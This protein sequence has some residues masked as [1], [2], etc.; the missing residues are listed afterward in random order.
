MATSS[1]ALSKPYSNED[2][3]GNESDTSRFER[4]ATRHRRHEVD[5]DSERGSHSESYSTDDENSNKDLVKIV[6]A[7]GRKVKRRSSYDYNSRTMSS[8][9]SDGRIGNL[10]EDPHVP[11]QYLG[12]ARNSPP[13]ATLAMSAALPLA[14]RTAVTANSASTAFDPKDTMDLKALKEGININKIEWSQPSKGA[15]GQSHQDFTEDIHPNREERL[16]LIAE[17]KSSFKESAALEP[18]LTL[19][20]SKPTKSILRPPREKFPEDPVPIREGV[21][22]LA[23]ARYDGIPPDARWTKISRRLVNPEALDLGK[24]RYEARED[25]VIVLRVLSREEVQGYAEVT[26]LIRGK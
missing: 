25:F 24:E 1:P 6:E 13:P 22:P 14:S 12:Y 5:R 23:K 10:V 11:G 2:S 20:K 18:S 8:R 19:S 3:L 15:L 17:I 4:G 26:R 7:L 16:D 9:F 21:A